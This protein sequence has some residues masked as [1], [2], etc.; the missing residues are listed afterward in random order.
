MII[1]SRIFFFISLFCV[2]VSCNRVPKQIISER[3]M[4][5]VLYDMLLAEAIVDKTPEL[6][7]TTDDKMIVY[8]AVFKKHKITQIEYDSSL[9]WYGKHTD[10]YMGVYRLVLKDYNAN[11]AAMRDV[12]PV[13]I[14]GDAFDGDSLDIWI[15]NRNE[16]F[17]PTRFF[18]AMIFDINPQD[19]YPQGNTYTL[20]LSVWGIPY[21]F[22]DKLKINISA[23]H[24]DTTISV[25]KEVIGDGYY[26]TK[27]G[28]IDSLDVERIYGYIYLNEVDAAYYR[29]Y[30]NN[31][32]L[33]KNKSDS[34]DSDE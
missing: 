10:L 17:S 7:R 19:P 33:I 3:K 5:V 9:I 29:I 11:M 27:I 1:K 23:V 31:I 28:T 16:V 2:V 20:A 8:N 12:K 21:N 6:Y 22:N 30:L 14:S 13:A 32:R 4:R 24:A 34:F 18:N 25:H 26:E 15:Y